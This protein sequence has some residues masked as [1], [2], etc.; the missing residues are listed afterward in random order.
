MEVLFELNGTGKPLSLLSKATKTG[1]QYRVRLSEEELY[2]ALDELQAAGARI[3]SVAQIK[4][5][6]EDFFVNLVDADRA[7]ANAVEV[8][9]K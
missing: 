6:L 7:Q 1:E 3:A 4:P 5:S 2:P 8:S 9:E